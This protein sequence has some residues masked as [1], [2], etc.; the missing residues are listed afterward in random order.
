MLYDK[1]L[2]CICKDKPLLKRRSVAIKSKVRYYYYECKKCNIC[3]FATR[4]E[5]FCRE[6]WNAAIVKKSKV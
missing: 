4:L 3:T 6:L 2:K 1:P 5:E